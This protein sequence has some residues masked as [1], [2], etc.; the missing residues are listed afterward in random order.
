VQEIKWDAPLGLDCGLGRWRL[1]SM[2][3]QVERSWEFMSQRCG[4]WAWPFGGFNLCPAEGS[5]SY[6][7]LAMYFQP[8]SLDS[9]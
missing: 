4:L 3:V 9:Q 6:I 1:H 2:A 8:I 5:S 7:V